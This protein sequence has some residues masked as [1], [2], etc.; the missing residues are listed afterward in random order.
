MRNKTYV[1]NDLGTDRRRDVRHVLDDGAEL[2][3]GHRHEVSDGVGLGHKLSLRLCR[4]DRHLVGDRRRLSL[5]DRLGLC[6]QSR[7]RPDLAHIPRVQLTLSM[8]LV[9]TYVWKYVVGTTIVLTSVLVTVMK[10]VSVWVWVAVA[11][12]VAVSVIVL[13]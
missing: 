10:S 6:T 9:L 2:S 11:V 3:D 5:L 4:E 1:V 13:V 12:D 8:T 7:K